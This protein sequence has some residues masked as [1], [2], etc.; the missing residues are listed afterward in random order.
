LRLISQTGRSV[1]HVDLAAC[2][3]HGIAVAA[4]THASP[5]AVAEHTWALIL[6]ALRRIPEDC[7]LMKRGAWRERFSLALRGRTLGVYGL[8]TIGSLVAAA[9]AAFGMRVLVFGQDA[10]R[11]R[12]RS[13]GYD[14]ARDRAR[15]FAESDVLSLHVRLNAATLGIVTRTDLACMKRTALFVNTARAELVEDGALADALRLGRPA[16]AAVDVYENEPVQHGDHPLLSL[17]NALCTP[18]SAW[19][20]QDTYELYFGEAFDNALAWAAGQPV[21]LILPSADASRRQAP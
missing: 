2:A 15:F 16:Y 8:G 19:V 14:I 6:A 10:S 1:H 5:H 17:D 4:G 3:G 18:H 9:A 11:Q 21:N 20:E 13:S 12:A 7:A